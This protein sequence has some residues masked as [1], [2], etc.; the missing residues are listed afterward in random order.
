MIG[1]KV[2]ASEN[3][4]QLCERLSGKQAKRAYIPIFI[5]SS[6]Q[7]V[8]RVFEWTWNIS[9]RLEFSKIA[10]LKSSYDLNSLQYLSNFEYSSLEKYLQDFFGKIFRKLK[11][12]NYSSKIS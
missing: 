11:E 10:V 7:Q 8:L 4:I 6:L 9:D 12:I 2:W 1:R 3:I 5:L